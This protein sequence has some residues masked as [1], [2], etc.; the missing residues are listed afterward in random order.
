[1]KDWPFEIPDLFLHTLGYRGD[2]RYVG[3]IQRNDDYFFIDPKESKLTDKWAFI[4]YILKS[5]VWLLDND[6]DF[7]STHM[8]IIDSI[9]QEGQVVTLEESEAIIAAQEF[10]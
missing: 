6:I 5:E 3:L 8:L 2:Q 1:M 4:E 10:H 9:L 7:S